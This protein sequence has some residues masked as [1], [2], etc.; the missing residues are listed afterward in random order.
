MFAVQDDIASAIVNQ[1]RGRLAGRTAAPRLYTPAVP[2]YEAYLMARHLV[3]TKHSPAAY[4][5]AE[6]LYRSAI[7]LDPGYAL[8][9]TGLAELFHIRAS[10]RGHS[11]REAAAM[12]RPAAERAFALDPSLP[13]AHMW[14][15]ILSSTYEYDWATAEHHF[16]R[17][18]TSTP[19]T[20][21]LRHMNGY[22]HLRFRGGA[23]EAVQE[24][25]RALQ[26]DPLNLIIRVGLVLSLY[27]ASR[28]R[29]AT[30]E[31]KRLLSQAPG[32]VPSYTLHVL[33]VLTEPPSAARAFAER[34]HAL[35]PEAAGSVGLLSGILKR[36]GDDDGAAALM[37]DV[38]ELGEYG[39]AVD[40]ALYRLVCGDLDRAFD[41]METLVE[42]QHP[43]LIM[44][45]VG[46][47]YGA[48][49]CA[50]SR[51]PAFARAIG[52]PPRHP[53]GH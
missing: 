13:D 12:I 35:L 33:N 45:L 4:V 48:T 28:D 49:L 17:A 47:P 1:L 36:E 50:S 25:R 15:G 43:F 16:A 37:R 44:V 51:W 39:N 31:G 10:L 8:P 52:L 14:L 22:F 41:A 6:E 3:W 26:D 46:G 29:D 38:S 19:V 42:Q 5:E 9:H 18:M 32:F 11:A 2:A 34:L 24:H 7:A 27:A 20:P 40:H 21:L 53:S 30:V 23:D